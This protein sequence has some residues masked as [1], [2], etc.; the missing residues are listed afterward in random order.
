MILEL[1]Y[2]FTVD[3]L[4]LLAVYLIIN[5]SLNLEYGLTGLPN[6]GKV[7]AVAGGAFVAGSVPGRLMAE[8][9]GLY[10]GIE[11]YANNSVLADCM[12]GLSLQKPKILEATEFI[13]DNVLI[14]TCINRVLSFD[15]FLSVLILLLT[16]FVAAGV[17]A[18]LGFISSY[19]AIRLREDYLAMTL[20][21]MGE[22]M[23]TIGYYTRDLV[24]GTLGVS[25][26]D[27]YG[28]TGVRERFLVATF[29]LVGVAVLAFV[30]SRI[31]ARSPLARILKAVRDQE[32]AAEVLGKDTVKV[33]RNI[34][35]ISASLASLAGALWAFYSGGVIAV[36]YDRIT[37]TFWPWVMVI[38][39]GS[40]SNLGVLL[41]TTIFVTARKF[42]DYYKFALEPVLPF[43]VVWLDRLVL[44]LVLLTI[45]LLRPAGVVPEKPTLTL[46]R[47]KIAELIKK[48]ESSGTG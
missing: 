30:Y 36:G 44:G 48:Q 1:V 47:E 28:W 38:V 7:L 32:I 10:R 17:G 37:W 21:A 34:L 25:V 23:W 22:F 9:F 46:S 43:S 13:E 35:M 29:V 24:G 8:Y 4:A 40:G 18:A 26:I 14:I 45:L 6:F 39:G 31:L 12:R 11:A 15:P 16:L 19:P 5:I 2:I 41:G 27:P 20:L 42:I 33:R 3:L